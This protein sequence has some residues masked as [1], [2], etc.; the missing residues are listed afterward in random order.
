MIGKRTFIFILTLLPGG[1]A[2]AQTDRTVLITSKTNIKRELFNYLVATKQSSQADE[3]NAMYQVDLV[4]KSSV[5]GVAIYKFGIQ[6]AHAG[7]N[8]VFRYRNKL[9]FPG[10]I[11]S[12]RLLTL[13][14]NFLSQYPKSFT[15]NEQKQLAESLFDI[16]EHREYLANQDELP[17]K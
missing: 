5:P 8:V 2:F 4:T 7:Y 1:H 10:S 14:G 3:Y 17:P 6:S 11:T 12:G 9:I 15:F 16:I 13:L